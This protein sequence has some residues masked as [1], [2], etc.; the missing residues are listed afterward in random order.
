MDK[1]LYLVYGLLIVPFAFAVLAV[2]GFGFFFKSGTAGA[3]ILI[4][5]FIVTKRKNKPEGVIALIGAFAFSIVGD[6]FLSNRSGGENY[7]SYGIAMFFLAHVGYLLFA[8]RNG[9]IHLLYT[10]LILVCYLSFFF[11]LLLPGFKS[12]SLM[13]IVLLYLLISCF[14]LGAALGISNQSWFK[15]F[16]IV[17]IGLILISDTIIALRE[18][19]NITG[20]DWLI[21]PTYYLAHLVIITSIIHKKEIVRVRL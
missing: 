4:L 17:G 19:A 14:S 5:L 21:L 20:G 12:I 8:L 11:F 3:G 7:F 2:L 1:K 13:L 16:Y 10:F 9:K 6:W 15:W 18:F